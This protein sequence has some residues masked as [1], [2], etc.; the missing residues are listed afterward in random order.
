MV[1]VIYV[2]LVFEI[3]YCDFLFGDLCDGGVVD[4]S[5][6][7]GDFFDDF[8]CCGLYGIQDCQVYL[9]EVDVG[10][11]VKFLFQG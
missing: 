11:V 8:G 1:E 9:Y 10:V 5:V 6:D 2:E 4:E 3:V 7:V